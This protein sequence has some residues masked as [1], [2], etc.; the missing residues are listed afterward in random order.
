MKLKK[1]L[2]GL[3]IFI[4]VLIGAIIAA[5]YLFK[6]QI[7][8]TIDE[9]IAANINAD[10]LFEIDNFSLSLLP[11]FPNITASIKQLGVIGRDEFAEEVLFSMDEFEVEVN[12]GKLLFNDQMSIEG[13]SLANPQIFIKVLADG[14]ANYDIMISSDE[15]EVDTTT[16]EAGDFSMAIEGWEITGG[17]IIYDDATIPA[18]IELEN[19]N[20]SGSG[21]FSLSIFDLELKT[22]VNLKEISYDGENYLSNRHFQADMILNMDLDQMKFTFKD[23]EFKLNQFVMGMDGWFSM[24]EAGFD[25][26][27]NISSSNNSFKSVLSLVP[28]L[29]A[30]DFDGLVASGSVDFTTTLKGLYNDD[31]MPAFTV[32]LGIKDGQFQYPD[33]P[34]TVSNVQLKMLVDNKGGSI[35]NTK[36][37]ISTFHMEL[38][39]NPIDASLKIANLVDY[40]IDLTA[41]AKINFAEMM[42]MFPMEGMELKGLLE[43]DIKIK[44]VYDSSTSTIPASGNFNLSDF[45]YVD[46]EYLPQGMSISTA[47]ASF[48]PDNMSLDVFES[49]V[50]QSDFAATG[51]LSNYLN[52]AFKQNEVLTGNLN[53][54]SNN[55]LIDEFMTATETEEEIIEADTASN[56]EET[57]DMAIPANIDFI[58]NANLKKIEYD[59]LLLTDAKGVVIIK[60]GILDMNDLSTKTLGGTIVFNGVYNT[61]APKDPK[62]DMDLGINNISIQ[63]SY[64]AFNTVQKLAP[65]AENMKGKLTTNFKMKGDLD[66]EL[67]PITKTVNGGG[68]LKIDEA[69]LIGSNFV[70]ALSRFMSKG[71][72]EEITLK[73]MIM[74]VT[75]TN[76]AVSV[77]PFNVFIDGHKS[78]IS[79]STSLDGALDYKIS[80]SVP[81][82]QLGQQANAALAKITGSTEE[83][84]SEI[85]LTL[86]VTGQYDSP[87]ISLIGSDTKDAIK[88]QVTEAAVDKAADL[89]KQNTGVD[90]PTSKE[91]LNKEAIEKARKEADNLL[92]EAQKQADQVKVEARKTADKVRA[93]AKIQNDKL[94]KDAGANPLMRKAAQI[95]GKKLMQEA[96]KQAIKM[97]AEGNK[98]ADVIMV[99]AQE[100]ADTLIKNAESK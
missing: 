56:S 1:I 94:I 64:K 50:G 68:V 61:K 7:K 48:N 32:N 77:A 6:N 37:D 18:Y 55:I 49:K 36:I 71:G 96:D 13:I 35:D 95:T 22:D 10:V 27:L 88:G 21:N 38:G 51:K 24:P 26:D 79:G 33:L 65:I 53:L 72:K 8:A 34:S 30:T 43:T 75:I 45:Y 91:A 28:A 54:T 57:Y 17:H 97:E 58:M 84:S 12:L 47:M 80:T 16:T 59:G 19:F 67:M 4:L 85:K 87:K 86:G 39:K 40:P 74:D 15:V 9:Q 23:N 11:N 90:I 46:E 98:Q 78:N 63:E 52:Y 76:G 89:I 25:M 73:G 3:S 92:A 29:Y 99:K 83:A 70:T 41:S 44:G 14:T 69:T 20:H 82:G 2:I 66:N 42:Q 100:K 81:A 62:F 31:R 60:D 5:P 93:E